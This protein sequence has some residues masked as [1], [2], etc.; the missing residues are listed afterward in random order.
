M[1]EI[2]PLARK[3]IQERYVENGSTTQV[4]VAPLPD[5]GLPGSF[6]EA[7]QPVRLDIL[8]GRPVNL[9]LDNQGFSADLCFS[10]PPVTCRFPWTAVLAVQTPEGS[11]AKTLVVTMAM[12]MGDG[13]LMTLTEELDE[14]APPAPERGTPGPSLRLV[15][16][17]D[18]T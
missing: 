6:L 7:G 2:V 5:S 9:A 14:K 17:T 13:S 1:T 3:L 10:G 15:R 8:A 16:D 11:L 18:D 12:V 4:V